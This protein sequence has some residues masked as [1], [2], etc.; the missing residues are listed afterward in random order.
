MRIIGCVFFVV[1]LVAFRL[2]WPPFGANI[3]KSSSV[4]GH[5]LP[6]KLQRW[7]RGESHS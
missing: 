7:A 3:A 1:A 6:K 4:I 5:F 2:M